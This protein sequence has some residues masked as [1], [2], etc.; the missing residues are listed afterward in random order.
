VVPLSGPSSIFLAL[1]SSGMNSQHFSF[2]GY[3]PIQEG[4]RTEKIKTLEVHS[5]KEGSCEIFME[6]PYR[7]DKLLQ[8]LLNKLSP[9]TRFCIAAG[10]TTDQELVISKKISEWRKGKL[11]ILNKIPTIFLLQA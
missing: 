1:M 9:N 10:L 3:L 7:N 5:Q 2:H 11:P 8:E 6:T 4:E